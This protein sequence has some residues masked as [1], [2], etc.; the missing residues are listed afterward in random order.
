MVPAMFNTFLLVAVVVIA[1]TEVLAK[2]WSPVLRRVPFATVSLLAV[3]SWQAWTVWRL[4]RY[5]QVYFLGIAIILLALS[6]TVEEYL[7][8]INGQETNSE[9]K[10]LI[11]GLLFLF[12]LLISGALLYLAFRKVKDYD[13]LNFNTTVKVP[14]YFKADMD[15]MKRLRP[16]GKV[17]S[18]VLFI[19]LI[20]RTI[21]RIIEVAS[22]ED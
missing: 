14:A 10:W 2:I 12:Q 22:K 15:S 7:P 11:Y 20:A 6:I 9:I 5:Y 16:G 21:W 17:Y 1:L 4:N 19:G 3:F 8:E 13:E 18:V